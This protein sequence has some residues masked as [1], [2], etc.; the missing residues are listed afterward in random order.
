[1][2][3]WTR[4]VFTRL[5][6]LVR[7]L[8]L[9]GVV[10]LAVFVPTTVVAVEYTARSEFC[11]TCHIMEPYYE[12]WVNSSHANVPCIDCHYEPGALETVEG[13]FQGLSQLAKYATRTE[14][15]KPWAEVSDQSCMRSG[16]HSVRKLEGEIDFGRIKFDHRHHLLESRRGRRLRCTSCHSQI[17]QG[18][19]VSVTDSVCFMCHFMPVEGEIPEGTS[20]CLSCH[21]PPEAPI[22]IAG[23]VFEHTEYIARGVD[24]Q[25]CH[26]PAVEGDGEVRRERCHSCHGEIGHIERFGETEFLHEMH[27]TEHKVECFEC[28]DEIYHGLLPVK[29]PEPAKDEGCG[30]CHEDSHGAAGKIYAGTGALGVADRPSRMFETRVVCEACHTGR[31][32]RF[33]GAPTPASHGSGTRAHHGGPAVAS[34]GEVDCIHCHGPGFSGMLTG[35]QSTVE[36]ELVRLA[37]LVDALETD[38]VESEDADAR[39]HLEEALTNLSLVEL[40]GSRGAHNV[41][42]V[43]DVLAA[44]S[45]SIDAAR[46]QLDPEYEPAAAPAGPFVSAEGC[47]EC[48]LGIEHEDEVFLNGRAFPH[49]AHLLGLAGLDCGACHTTDDAGRAGHGQPSF[50][51][52]DC[53]SC[54]HEE[55]DDEAFDPYDCSSCHAHQESYVAGAFEGFAELPTEMT[56]KACE[57]CHGEPPDIGPPN[58]AL[59][60][61]CHDEDYPPMVETWRVGTT[62]LEQELRQ[63]LSGAA[64]RGVTPEAIERARRALEL[65]GA[66]GSR[67]AHNWPFTEAILG[68][69]LAGLE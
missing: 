36:A 49:D 65:I 25:E 19:H 39:R 22:E 15:T 47:S 20:D 18:D 58:T 51:R 42:Y 13:K 24:C 3:L 40:D 8:L 52:E 38:L 2:L 54:H 63:A 4:R 48:H 10:A 44:V 64:E 46:E 53:A 69:A 35:W 62:E 41:G 27:V 50:S 21:G 12:S 5:D 45:R 60:A 32:D 14:G 67:G 28:H 29:A 17:V 1:M 55:R 34:A 23:R 26:A 9:A 33:T 43:L 66:D 6:M 11:N 30:T 16:C 61:L 56:E 37:P 31:S 57:E 59:C 7:W 68:E